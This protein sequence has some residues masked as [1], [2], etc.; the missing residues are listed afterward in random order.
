MPML[1]IKHTL[2]AA[3][4]GL[5]EWCAED[6][7]EEW[8]MLSCCLSVAL[9][10]LAQAGA[11]DGDAPNADHALTEGARGNTR[12]APWPFLCPEDIFRGILRSDFGQVKN[13]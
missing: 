1:R 12:Y 7:P 2:L 10:L 9:V 11:G 6:R 4:A 8:H 3:E 5:R 13:A